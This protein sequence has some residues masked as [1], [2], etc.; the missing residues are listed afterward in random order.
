M[1]NLDLLKKDLIGK[2]NLDDK[3]IEEFL[4]ENQIFFLIHLKIP[5]DIPSANR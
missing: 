4:H 3:Q 2:F 1:L 5:I